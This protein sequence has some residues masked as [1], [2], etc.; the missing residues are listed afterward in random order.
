MAAPAS[1]SNSLAPH[2][3]PPH[4]PKLSL[5]VLPVALRHS[6]LTFCSLSMYA[7]PTRLRALSIF[8]WRISE[9]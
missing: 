9:P 6:I 5:H 1:L 8:H 7:Q 3:P 4:I 2:S